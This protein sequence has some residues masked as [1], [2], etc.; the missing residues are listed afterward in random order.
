MQSNVSYQDFECLFTPARLTKPRRWKAVENGEFTLEGNIVLSLGRNGRLRV[1]ETGE[2]R[3]NLY[4]P[5]VSDS[6][7]NPIPTVPSSKPK[8]LLPPSGVKKR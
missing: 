8:L 5:L 7:A 4:L 6:K 2:E 1:G 3:I